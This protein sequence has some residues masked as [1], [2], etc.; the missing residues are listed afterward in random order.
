MLK[1]ILLSA[2]F[3]AIS[4]CGVMQ[5]EAPAVKVMPVVEDEKSDV[6]NTQTLE[7]GLESYA[8]VVDG[9]FPTPY[10]NVVRD[11]TH[12]AVCLGVIHN[13]GPVA[14]SQVGVTKVFYRFED[15]DRIT[16]KA[17]YVLP[18]GVEPKQ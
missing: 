13:L 7:S 6:D 16:M 17:V 15:K 10:V 2:V 5:S 11:I 4:G 1:T 9:E 14:C 18:K 8:I 12:R 3:F